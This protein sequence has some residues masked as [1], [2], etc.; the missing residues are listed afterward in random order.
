MKG[1]VIPSQYDSYLFAWNVLVLTI[2]LLTYKRYLKLKHSL[3]VFSVNL[4]LSDFLN[5]C[6][7]KKYRNLFRIWITSGS[8]F[9]YFDTFFLIRCQ[10][11][12]VCNVKLI[13]S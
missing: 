1:N 6:Q 11:I 10:S 13:S 12:L 8:S 2:I 4:R 3:A 5:C 7:M 9:A